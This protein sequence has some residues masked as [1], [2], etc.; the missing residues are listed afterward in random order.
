MGLMPRL[1]AAVVRILSKRKR[2]GRPPASLCPEDAALVARACSLY[3]GLSLGE[4]AGFAKVG[5]GGLSRERLPAKTRAALVA[6]V[7]A[8]TGV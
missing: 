5:R 4:L 7:E 3:G 6:L 1:P 2:A 8:K